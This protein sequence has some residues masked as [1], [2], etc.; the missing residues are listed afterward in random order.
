MALLF[1]GGRK[2]DCATA[3]MHRQLHVLQHR[4]LLERTHDLMGASDALFYQ[5]R[6]IKSG[7]ITAA[8]MNFARRRALRSSDH[9]EERCLAC[10][11]GA[12]EAADLLLRNIKRHVF[13]RGHA[14]KVLRQRRYFQDFHFFFS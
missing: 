3:V 7:D 4:E 8:K 11:V 1:S 12:D 9:A 14:P 5:G 10:T 6:G 13:Q 2:R